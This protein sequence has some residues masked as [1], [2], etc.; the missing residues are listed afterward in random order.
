[1]DVPG[2]GIGGLSGATTTD[3]PVKVAMPQGMTCSGK[4]AGVNNVCIVRMRNQALAGP[5]GGSAAFT[6]SPAAKKRAVEFNL[7][8]RHF[9]RGVLGAEE[10]SN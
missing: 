5:F 10:E 7:R 4:V 6:Q 9:A 3:F 2:I 1:M 8:K